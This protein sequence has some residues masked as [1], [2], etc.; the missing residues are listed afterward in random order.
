[1]VINMLPAPPKLQR[2]QRFFQGLKVR[3]GRGDILVQP[4]KEDIASARMHDPEN[5]AYAQCLKRML[6]TQRVHVYMTVAYIQTLDEKGEEIMERYLIKDHAH[7]YIKRFDKGEPVA[8]GGFILHKPTGSKTLEHKRKFSHEWV[9]KN[10]EKARASGRKSWDKRQKRTR[11]QG[12]GVKAEM[13]GTFRSGVGQVQFL[14]SYDGRLGVHHE[15][16]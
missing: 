15:S 3:E 7:A 12:Q 1:M 5:C 2:K 9:Q 13:I 6:Q 4:S 11:V 16:R 8:P 14:G 10:I